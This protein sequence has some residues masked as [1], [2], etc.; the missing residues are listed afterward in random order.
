MFAATFRRV[1]QLLTAQ[2]KPIQ[3]ELVRKPLAS[4]QLSALSKRGFASD[5]SGFNSQ[6]CAVLGAQWGDEGKGKLVDILAKRYDII[7]RFNGGANAGHTLVVDGKKYAFHLLPCGIL[8]PGKIN[9]IGNGVVLHI[10]TMLKELDNLTKNGIDYTGR[11]KISNRAHVLFDFHQVIDGRQED[12]LKGEKIGTTRRGIGPCYGSKIARQG[13]RVADLMDPQVFE[14]KYNQLLD[15]MRRQFQFDYDSK[16]ELDRYAKYRSFLKDQKMVV[17]SITFLADAIRQKKTILAEGANAAL[18][19]IDFGTYP[20]VTSSTTSAGGVCTGLGIPPSLVQTSIGIVKA[21]TTR[22]GEGPFPTELND[23]QG[24]LMRKTG[25]EFGTTTGRPRR[26]G[27]L[28]VPVVHFSHALNGFSSINI[29]KLDVLSP[30]KEVKIGVSYELDG[31]KLGRGEIPATLKD[32]ARVK[33]NY[34]TMEGWNSDISK[35]KSYK[36]LPKQAQAYLKRIEELAGLP[37]SWIGTGP[38]RHD[39]VTKGFDWQK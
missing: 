38:G 6:I 35:V 9:L 14:G 13:V 37:I 16:E 1:S 7:G 5:I 11:L 25:H 30:F 23:D 8:Y 27:W 39:M 33:V 26:C 12:A 24:E 22:V 36:E 15:T 17:D 18:L 29:T 20:Y 21:Y 3:R 4:S 19:D 32:L 10:P 2:A 31:R 34:E 28:D